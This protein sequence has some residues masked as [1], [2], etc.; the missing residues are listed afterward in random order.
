LFR[1]NPQT[2]VDW[3]DYTD[4]EQLRYAGLSDPCISKLKMYVL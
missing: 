3:L 2:L 4:M 1:V